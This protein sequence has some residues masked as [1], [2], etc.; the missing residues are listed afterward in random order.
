MFR[1][2]FLVTT[3]NIDAALR[4]EGR[5][6]VDRAD[7]MVTTALAKYREIAQNSP[8]R[9]AALDRFAKAWD[10][11]S[12]LR[13]AL[14]L[15]KPLRAGITMPTPDKIVDTFVSNENIMH[16]SV[17]L[18]QVIEESESRAMA[19]GARANYESARLVLVVSV[20]VGLLAALGLAFWVSR[21]IRRQLDDVGE[22]LEAV[23]QGDLTRAATVRSRDELGQMAAAVNRA[24]A[25]IR[26]T[27]GTLAAG[28]QTL[29]GNSERLTGATRRIADSA[30]TTA[31]K[32]NVVASA[33]SNV[34]NN[35]Q[36]VAA[37]SDEMGLSITEIARNANEAARVASEAVSVAE[38][39]NQTVSKLGESSAE[40][41]NV[42]K[43]ITSIAEQTNLL[44]LNATIEAARA[45]DA[46]KGF[47]VVA[48]EV[49]DLAQETARATEDISRRVDAIQSDTAN[50]VEAI[51]SIGRIIAKINDY[52]VTIA[53]AVE[54]QTATTAEM[55][56][57]V[58][59]AANGT[60]EIAATISE[61]A[62]AASTTTATLG[63]ADTAVT[64]LSRLATELNQVVG[65][66]R[67]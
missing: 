31:R 66:F 36:T 44:A 50:A 33:A 32:V 16:E 24:N 35:V 5:R 2:L 39:T 63:E 59:D 38:S 6:E 21:M 41:G 11:H 27:V 55:S 18:L 19:S 65:R 52:Q 61:V 4:D 37:G 3:P 60:A 10:I 54:E 56:R 23:A 30:Q 64:E 67:V 62:D 7:A 47:A 1:G 28:A 20:L 40:I 25:N 12:G 17:A 9:L 8:K 46:G 57:N 43:V 29:G 58:G 15:G 34:S 51:E 48:S 49:K 53:S 26:E 14:I 22:S 42:V 13:D 45:G